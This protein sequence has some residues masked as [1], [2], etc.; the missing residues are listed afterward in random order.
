MAGADK[1]LPP[2]FVSSS[3]SGSSGGV[4]G[5]GGGGGGTKKFWDCGSGL[6]PT[7]GWTAGK[8]KPKK[9]TVL[10]NTT[11]GF[12]SE[13]NLAFRA[14]GGGG[15][16]LLFLKRLSQGKHSLTVLVS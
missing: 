11:G 13:G 6:K 4:G 14:Q 3:A 12:G 2:L 10:R 1:K 5:G 15:G 7:F 16:G 9:I 8:R